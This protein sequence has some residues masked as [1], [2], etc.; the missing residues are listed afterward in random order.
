MTRLQ[1]NAGRSKTS[2]RHVE[3]SGRGAVTVWLINSR[4]VRRTPARPSLFAGRFSADFAAQRSGDL[5]P[6]HSRRFRML[7]LSRMKDQKIRL[8]TSDGPV[9][10]TVCNVGHGKARLGFE[11]PLAVKI[12]RWEHLDNE[13]RPKDRD[14]DQDVA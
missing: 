6:K 11:A 14:G 4:S 7:V 13:G 8:F 3:P 5:L 10:L 1:E 2:K 9:D 12:L